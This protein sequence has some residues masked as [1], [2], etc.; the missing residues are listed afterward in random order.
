MARRSASGAKAAIR[1][2]FWLFSRDRVHPYPSPG[3]T[4]KRP[5]FSVKVNG[6]MVEGVSNDRNGDESRFFVSLVQ[7]R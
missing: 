1:V 3:A 4:E 2:R 6:S 7:R 5:H